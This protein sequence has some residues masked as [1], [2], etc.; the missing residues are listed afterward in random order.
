MGPELDH[1]FL[2]VAD[3]RT[4][5]KMMEEAGLAV[6]YSRRHPGQGTTNLCACLDDMFLELLWLDGSQMSAESERIGLGRRGRGEGSPIGIAWRGEAAIQTEPY[7]APFLPEGVSIPV[8]LASRDVAVPF[9]FQSPGGTR[10]ID[11]TDG[12]V[13][14][15]QRPELA[16][17]GRCTLSVPEFDATAALLA[18]FSGI[19][20]RQG[21]P[22]IEIDVLNASKRVVRQIEWKAAWPG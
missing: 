9:V 5:R 8:A 12:L 14:D 17:L 20:V 18:G 4:A 6:N 16:T 3:E 10:P 19:D 21:E 15:R 2:F 13:G 11:R 1:L 22:R 7:A